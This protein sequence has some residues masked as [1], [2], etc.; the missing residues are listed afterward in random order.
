MVL[1]KK[2]DNFNNNT[3]IK[4]TAIAVIFIKTNIW[5]IIYLI[6]HLQVITH[7]LYKMTDKKENILKAALEL[8][9]NDGYNAVSTNA[10]AKKAGVSEGLIFR[11]FENKNA[12]LTS[13]MQL[14]EQKISIVFA[15][16]IFET[17]PHKVIINTISIP[18]AIHESE[19]DFWRLQF[20]LKW[21]V[22]YQNEEKMK[23]LQNKLIWA[24]EQLGYNNPIL[25]AKFLEQIIETVSIGILRY[26]IASQLEYREFL[27]NKYQ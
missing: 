23:P 11:H 24:F 3:L 16:V 13:I 12:L 22:K 17:D 2:L 27:I 26:G 4:M 7:I 8:F 1:R 6:I 25:E 21:E 14:A 18:F 10:I 15:P 20:K 19:Y 9:A 5:Q